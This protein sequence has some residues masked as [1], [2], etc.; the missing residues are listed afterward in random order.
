MQTFRQQYVMGF[1]VSAPPPRRQPFE[2]GGEAT[3]VVEPF[4]PQ[5]ISSAAWGPHLTF[6]PILLII[7]NVASVWERSRRH[8][9]PDV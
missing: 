5:V 2:R 3:G 4:R 6:L 9:E 8:L 7:P 1:L